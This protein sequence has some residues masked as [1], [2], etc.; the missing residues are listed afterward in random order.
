MQQRDIINVRRAVDANLGK[1]VRVKANRGRHKYS[2]TEGVLTESYPSIFTVKL[3]ADCDSAERLVS[4]SYT[5][6]LTRDVQLVIC[7]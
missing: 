5:D 6:V 2:I 4:Y 1:K 3:S 7:S